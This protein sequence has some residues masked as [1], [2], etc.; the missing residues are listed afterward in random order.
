MHLDYF[1]NKYQNW[2]FKNT[3]LLALSIILVY[4]LLE[5]EVA[6]NFILS[7]EH[8]GYLGV[9]LAGVFF[10]SVFTVTPASII[11]FRFSEIYPAGELALI[12]GFGGVVG[13][14]VIFSFLK[15]NIFKEFEP[16]INR[17][18]NKPFKLFKTPFFFWL[19]AV[20]GALIVASPLP[21]EVGIGLMGISRLKTWQFV[22]LSFTLNVFGIYLIIKLASII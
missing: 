2:H 6:Q 17:F 12:A 16:Y 14:L 21:D 1:R 9:F 3:T 5:T 19:P 18:L 13:D 8:I 11:L 20:L 10:V 4:F 15:E 22:I 7:I